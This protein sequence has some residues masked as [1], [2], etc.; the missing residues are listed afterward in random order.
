MHLYC[1]QGSAD[2]GKLHL[3]D[4]QEQIS[5]M[6]PKADCIFA[7]LS[8][9]VMQEL[10]AALVKDPH[11]LDI[12]SEQNNLQRSVSLRTEVNPA[13]VGS[14]RLAAQQGETQYLYNGVVCSKEWSVECIEVC[15][16]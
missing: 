3:Q 8:R 10:A 6:K 9:E 12:K 15:L 11:L 1:Q 14:A 13:C 16:P 5:E 4:A 7:E 2:V